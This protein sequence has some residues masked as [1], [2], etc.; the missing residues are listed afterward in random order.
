M[1]GRGKKRERIFFEHLLSFAVI[2]QRALPIRYYYDYFIDKGLNLR[3]IFTEV[4]SGLKTSLILKP[5]ALHDKLP[6]REG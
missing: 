2:L 6:L 1:L 5:D 3:N 4:E